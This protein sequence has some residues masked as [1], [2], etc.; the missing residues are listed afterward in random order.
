LQK[1]DNIFRYKIGFSFVLFFGLF[2]LVLSKAFYIQVLNRNKLVDYSDRQ[3]LRKVKIYPNRGKIYDRNG[4]PLA[5]N[6]KSY[7]IFSLPQT[8]KVSRSTLKKL[9]KYLPELNI[10]KLSKKLRS[11]KRYTWIV[12]KRKLSERAV[13]KIKKLKKHGIYLEKEY[14]RFYPNEEVGS[15]VLGFVG[16]DHKGLSGIEYQFDKDLKGKPIVVKYLKDAKNRPVKFETPKFVNHN[17][18]LKLT[19]DIGLQAY[20]EKALKESVLKHKAAS[21]GIGVMDATTGEILALANYPSFNANKWKRYPAKN[22]KLSFISDPIEPGSIFKVFPI[23]SGLENNLI[24]PDS[25]FY[26]ERGAFRVQNHVIR[27]ADTKKKFEWLSVSDILK[28]SSNIGTTKI[29]FELSDKKFFKTLDKFG[30][31]KKTGVELPGESRGILRKEKKISPL[32]LS[33]ISFGQ[34]VAVNGLQMMSAYSTIANGGYKVTPRIT[35]SDDLPEKKRVIS[36]KIHKQ[37]ESMLVQAVENGTGKSAKVPFFR[38]AGKTSTAQKAKKSGGYKDYIPGFIGYPTGLE[39]PFVIYAYV[40]A[41][42]EK[43]YYGSTVAGPIFRKIAQH[44]LFKEKHLKTRIPRI[45]M[46]ERENRTEDKVKTKSSAIKRLKTGIIPNFR[47]L[48]KKT[49]KKMAEKLGMKIKMIGAGLNTRQSISAG[50]KINGNAISLMF[51]VPKY[52]E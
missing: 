47:G 46:E 5:V 16:T 39:K 24:T 30:I 48:D 2:F 6:I 3:F 29:A 49:C 18:G 43:G 10:R 50:R 27:E 52:E 14:I 13:A 23:I 22:R 36:R 19:L 41:P 17:E 8:Q 9:K 28:Y 33:N 37:L 7:S 15:Q 44:I 21:G 51:K 40:D 4:S 38:I 25:N 35:A 26:C 34:G 11:R 42:T 1:K 20:A 12:R 31:G 32:S 45:S